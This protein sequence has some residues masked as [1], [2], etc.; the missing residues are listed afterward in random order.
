MIAAAR[1]M[2]PKAILQRHAFANGS[3]DYDVNVDCGGIDLDFCDDDA[4]LRALGGV[5]VQAGDALAAARRRNR[6]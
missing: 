2:M 5:L 6:K 1:N 4:A 3:V